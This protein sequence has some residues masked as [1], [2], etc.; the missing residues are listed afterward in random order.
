[1]S[2]DIG[3][4][5][6]PLLDRTHASGEPQIVRGPLQLLHTLS[7]T[8]R[9]FERLLHHPASAHHHGLPLW[10]F[11]SWQ[12]RK[13]LF[14]RP[15]TIEAFDGARLRCYPDNAA[16]SGVIYLGWPDWHE[17]QWLRDVLRPGDGFLDVGA[18]VGVYS[19]LAAARVKP[20]GEILAVEAEPSLAKRLLDNLRLNGFDER[21]VRQVAV[22]EQAGTCRFSFG[23]DA[24]GSVLADQSSLVGCDV[25]MQTL[26]DLVP[27]PARF[28]VGKIDI[29]GY[30]LAA[31]RGA[32]R[33]LEA[34]RPRCWL[35]ET[36]Q[37]SKRYGSTRAELQVLLGEYGFE[38]FEVLERGRV[39]KRVPAGG[40]FYENSLAV[41]DLEWLRSRLPG[42]VVQ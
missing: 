8:R 38:F 29:E 9:V 21:S 15:V 36:N 24:V 26:D 23:K 39:L 6:G 3:T 16:T 19:V 40:P 14:P 7:T 22:G 10:K 41:A 25:T 33:L 28:A 34:R 4:V 5:P 17:M 1:M 12:L 2:Q 42:L 20:G 30:E 32:R 13:R 35:I 37:A 11:A 31:F 18:N 27:D